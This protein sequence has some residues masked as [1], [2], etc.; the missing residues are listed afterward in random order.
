MRGKRTMRSKDGVRKIWVFAFIIL[1]ACVEVIPMVAASGDFQEGDGTEKNPYIIKT[2]EQLYNIRENPYAHYKLGA[3]IDLAYI[4]HSEEG[5][6][7]IG[8]SDAPFTGTF[9]GNG[10]RI[11]N[12]NVKGEVDGLGLFG[13][14]GRSG[15]IKNVILEDVDIDYL[16]QNKTS[17]S[18]V[19]M[20]LGIIRNSSVTNGKVTGNESIGGL[21]GMNSGRIENSSAID[22][23]VTG[24]ESIGGLVGFNNGSIENSSSNFNVYGEGW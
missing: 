8:N 19:G 9:D 23:K 2:D 3:D 7:P 17:G 21:V 6:V 16:G 22:G 14:V 4:H 20:N 10:F 13:V 12:L 15:M 24:N 1:L 11:R 5:W 18:L